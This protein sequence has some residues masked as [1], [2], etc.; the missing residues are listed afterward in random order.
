MNFEKIEIAGLVIITPDVFKDDRGVFM[1][2]F[3]RET[4]AKNGLPT[5]FVQDNQSVSKKHVLRGLHFQRPP[6]AQGKLVSVVH[7]AVLDVAVDLRKNSPT[8][9]QWKS[10]LLNKDNRLMFWIPEG[11]AHGFIAMEENTIFQYKCTNIYHKES[12]GGIRWNDPT[13]NIAWGVSHPVL[14]EKDAAAPLFN[15]IMNDNYE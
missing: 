2:T 11:F 3:H 14:S 8:Y 13:L 4:F 15:D 12:E 6:Y 10:V 9:G 1:E 7:G 5:H